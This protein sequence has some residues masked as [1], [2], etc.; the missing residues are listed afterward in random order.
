MR[1]LV[2]EPDDSFATAVT[3]HLTLVGFE[4]VHAAGLHRWRRTSV[5][6]RTMPSSLISP[7]GA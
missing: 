4:A 3:E 5:F 6:G 1:V 2:V 7:C